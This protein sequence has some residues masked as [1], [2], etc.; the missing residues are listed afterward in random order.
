MSWCPLIWGIHARV[1]LS[2]IHGA[3]QRQSSTPPYSLVCSWHLA[4]PHMTFDHLSRSSDS[5][6]TLS[7]SVSEMSLSRADTILALKGLQ[8]EITDSG[9][10][11]KYFDGRGRVIDELFGGRVS[12]QVRRRNKQNFLFNSLYHELLPGVGQQSRAQ[13][14]GVEIVSC[15]GLERGRSHGQHKMTTTASTT[16]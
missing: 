10:V 13:R 2:Y 4:L 9:A 7:G 6:P 14:F 15:I 5:F 12:F 11:K 3:R 1:W 8:P 16:A